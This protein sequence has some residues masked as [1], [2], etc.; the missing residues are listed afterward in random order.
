MGRLRSDGTLES[1]GTWEFTTKEEADRRVAEHDTFTC[2]I[3]FTLRPILS[4]V[5]GDKCDVHSDQICS[6]CSLTPALTTRRALSA[7]QLSREWCKLLQEIASQLTRQC[8]TASGIESGSR[9]CAA[10]ATNMPGMHIVCDNDTCN[11]QFC[12][13]MYSGAF[14]PPAGDW[15]CLRFFRLPFFP[16]KKICYGGAPLTAR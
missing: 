4:A 15:Y 11:K 1:S 10:N 16:P 7:S 13:G 14:W 2:A 3:C 6:Q 12:I 8:V 5:V 9:A